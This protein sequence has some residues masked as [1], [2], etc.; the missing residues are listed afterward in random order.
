MWIGKG[1]L[2][3]MLNSLVFDIIKMNT[4]CTV[5][6]APM[7]KVTSTKVS[8]PHEIEVDL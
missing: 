4:Y 8:L 2:K 7:G 5:Y 6:L 1:I 3:A